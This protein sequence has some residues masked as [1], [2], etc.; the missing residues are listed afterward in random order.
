MNVAPGY[1]Q[2]IKNFD[3]LIVGRYNVFHTNFYFHTDHKKVILQTV[4]KKMIKLIFCIYIMNNVINWISITLILRKL[5]LY[6]ILNIDVIGMC[7]IIIKQNRYLI[8]INLILKN[9]ITSFIYLF[10]KQTMKIIKHK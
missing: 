4:I 7:R 3:V 8:I 2:S 9:D 6:F 10:Y 1:H 5:I